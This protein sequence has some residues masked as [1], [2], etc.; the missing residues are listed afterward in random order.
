MV[1]S[2]TR[3]DTLFRLTSIC[4]QVVSKRGGEALTGK[5]GLIV[6][7]R[8]SCFGEEAIVGNLTKGLI[9]R[10]K[11]KGRPLPP[12]PPT[13]KH[14]R[15]CRHSTGTADGALRGFS[16]SPSAV[17]LMYFN[18]QI[19]IYDSGSLKRTKN[20]HSA[21]CYQCADS[22]EYLIHISMSKQW[23][24]C[25]LQIWFS[26]AK[27]LF[28]PPLFTAMFSLTIW[29]ALKWGGIKRNN[30]DQSTERALICSQRGKLPRI[31]RKEQNKE[32]L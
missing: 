8:S 12:L 7:W 19:F 15:V 27:H 1:E 3:S 14:S 9:W 22:H 31:I 25:V 17:S 13:S 11:V 28:P 26:W 23:P 24:D 2:S 18:A 29:V 20:Q 5:E 32:Q 6:R 4:L 10:L 16:L 30:T 21:C